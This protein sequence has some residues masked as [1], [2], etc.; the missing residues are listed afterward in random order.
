MRD[1]G[2]KDAAGGI[3]FLTP[4]QNS[5]CK[6]NRGLR[7][8]PCSD[9]S[10]KTGLRF[11]SDVSPL[12]GCSG[13]HS[14]NVPQNVFHPGRPFSF[15]LPN[16]TTVCSLNPDCACQFIWQTVESSL[17]SSEYKTVKRRLNAAAPT[18]G[19]G[20]DEVVDISR[21]LDSE[22]KRWSSRP[23]ISF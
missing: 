21:S 22:N 11:E 10:V 12:F 18:G 20:S 6:V 4:M 9:A 16:R 2:A 23:G 13:A 14:G 17:L 5:A 8:W 19:C 1:R 15:A 7:Y 3:K